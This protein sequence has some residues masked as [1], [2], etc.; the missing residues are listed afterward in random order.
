M[1]RHSTW[2]ATLFMLQ[3]V[4]SGCL[5]DDTVVD[6]DAPKTFVAQERDFQTFQTWQSFL[7][8]AD[9]TQSGAHMGGKV[10]A[11]V[12]TLP[13]KGSTT[14]PVGSMIVKTIETGDPTKWN[15]HSMVKRGGDFNLS[16]AKGWEYIELQYNTNNVA[17]ILWRG[18][19]PPLNHGYEALTPAG[20]ITMKCNDCHATSK[21]T[22][23]VMTPD[24]DIR[25]FK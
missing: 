6:P 20:T 7:V 23:Y 22:D 11:Y 2:P 3:L 8:D 12:N 13:P 21:D 18:E 25:N 5:T 9:G 17:V 14:Y 15:I 16:G 4:V 10:T 19:A 1:R 24:L